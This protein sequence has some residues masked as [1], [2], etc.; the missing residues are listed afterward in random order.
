MK[1]SYVVV[2]ASLA[3]TLAA[4]C[5]RRP[6][7]ITPLPFSE[8]VGGG[9]TRIDSGS[10]PLGGD[11]SNST[12]G[13]GN[14]IPSGSGFRPGVGPIGT[15]VGGGNLGNLGNQNQNLGGPG[16]GGV[17]GSTADTP[18]PDRSKWD[19]WPQDPDTLRGDT[20]YFD[21][22]KSV[23][24]SSEKAKVAAIAEYLKGHPGY[25][26]KLD[27]HCDER[28]TE[29][30]NRALGE[31]RAL[32]VREVLLNLG[33]SADAVVT[34]TYGEDRPAELGHNEAAWAKNRRAE[35]VVLIPPGS[36]R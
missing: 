28:G 35:P 13:R 21:F 27:G 23:V 15:D 18:L 30:Y 3:A 20:V 16:L 9:I 12:L 7:N 4:G 36:A 1:L 6:K 14:A 17:G 8:R 19:S 22:D 31:R 26:L 34:S 33:V 24:K 25:M 2:A 32:S 29:E 5:S 10:S 11:T